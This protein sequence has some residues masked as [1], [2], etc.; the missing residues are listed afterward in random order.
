M[1]SPF[2][3]EQKIRKLKRSCKQLFACMFIVHVLNGN[4][5]DHSIF[6]RLGSIL[7]HSL[8]IFLLGNYFLLFFCSP[9]RQVIL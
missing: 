4:I 5:C 2:D 8:T 6:F 3:L 1:N 9:I 7:F